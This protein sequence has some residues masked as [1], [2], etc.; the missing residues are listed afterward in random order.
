MLRERL[1]TSDEVGRPLAEIPTGLAVRILRGNKSIGFWE[2]GAARLSAGDRIVE[3]VP[4]A[5]R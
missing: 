1:I 3:I 5:A 2:V 4:R